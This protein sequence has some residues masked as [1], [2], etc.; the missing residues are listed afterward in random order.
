[1]TKEQDKPKA[2]VDCQSFSHNRSFL[3]NSS[4][5]KF[6]FCTASKSK[7]LLDEVTDQQAYNL[8]TG[9]NLTNT[10]TMGERYHYATTMRRCENHCGPKAKWFVEKV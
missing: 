10:P 3:F 6:G 5:K 1:M 4:K 7:K 2:C 8:V 9:S